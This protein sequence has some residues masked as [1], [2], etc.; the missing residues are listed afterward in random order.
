MW[1]L[2]IL[3]CDSSSSKRPLDASHHWSLHAQNL[4]KN[5]GRERLFLFAL[6]NFQRVRLQR[7]ECLLWNLINCYRIIV[8]FEEF[9]AS[10]WQWN[11]S[12]SLI[13]KVGQWVLNSKSWA[14]GALKSEPMYCAKFKTWRVLHNGAKK[15]DENTELGENQSK[16]LCICVL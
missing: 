8:W 12:W 4:Q 13:L 14:M 15:L 16:L 5:F 6:L 9:T 10:L 2:F 3:V 1:I 11:W 7:R